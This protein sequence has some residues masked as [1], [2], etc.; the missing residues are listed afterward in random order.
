MTKH[1]HLKDR[2]R[3]RMSKTGESY[4][5]ARRR[6]IAAR[7][8]V[9]QAE[10]GYRLRGGVHPDTAAFANTLANADVT[11]SGKSPSEAL[12]LG[13]GGGLGAGYILWQFAGHH[14]IVTLGFRN[15]WQYPDRW[16]VKTGRRLGIEPAIMETSG[17]VSALRSL[18]DALTSPGPRPLVWIDAQ[19]IGYWHMPQRFSGHGG[20][21]IVIYQELEGRFLVDDRNSVPLSVDE[22]TLTAARG[23]VPS[24]RN[25]LVTFRVPDDIPEAVLVG[26]I[27]DGLA[28]QVSHLESESDSFS[29]PAW[30]KW[31]RML[32]DTRQKKG[33]ANA[34]D[35]QVGLFGALLSMY[36][37]IESSGY[38]GGTL[39]R[40]YAIF[41]DEA[42]EI[43]ECPAL[44]SVADGYRNLDHQWI[45]LAER[46]A[47]KDVGSFGHARKLIDALHEHMLDGGDAARPA[48]RGVAK[49]LWSLRDAKDGARLFEWEAFA[50]LLE[51]LGNEMRAIYEG[52]CNVLN[53]LASVVKTSGFGS[54][55]SRRT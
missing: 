9:E 53:E 31:A 47:P 44:K 42:A 21:P 39:R 43:L 33:W 29:L 51:D 12:I 46:A 8:E 16:L 41:L 7:P 4:S 34:F 55:K 20:Y 30:R 10:T 5:A 2:V 18:R 54:S 26:A 38:G 52:E 23:R 14:P 32:T 35:G 15:Q 17:H 40:L 19:E 6:V 22:A 48:A 13:I 1:K 27:E 50:D 3:A 24:Y 45:Q 25:R 37:S 11:T 49:E 36:E 28:D